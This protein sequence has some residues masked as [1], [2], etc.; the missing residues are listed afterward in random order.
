MFGR[1]NY[2]QDKAFLRVLGIE[3]TRADYKAY[4]KEQKKDNLKSRSLHFC[5]GALHH[6]SWLAYQENV[7]E[8]VGEKKVTFDSNKF[9]ANCALGEVNAELHFQA[10]NRVL[11]TR[12]SLGTSYELRQNDS[13][14][15]LYLSTIIENPGEKR[16]QSEEN[17]HKPWR[18]L[19]Q[20]NAD[21]F[22]NGVRQFGFQFLTGLSTSSFIAPA[23][24]C[25]NFDKATHGVATAEKQSVLCGNENAA[26]SG[27]LLGKLVQYSVVMPSVLFIPNMHLS[28]P[29]VGVMLVGL[30]QSKKRNEKMKDFK[31]HAASLPDREEIAHREGKS[32]LRTECITRLAGLVMAIKLSTMLMGGIKDDHSKTPE[33]KKQ[34]AITTPVVA[35]STLAHSTPSF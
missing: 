6:L 2:Y 10:M 5:V 25:N 20:K 9:E 14:H 15:G 16:A 30:A 7:H 12:M 35:K 18:K 23:P 17:Y 31:E 34:Y 22:G 29:L 21:S 32:H 1:N 4:K 24:L 8:I 26:I 27:Y 11:N 3:Y 33:I 28:I 13:G 19:P